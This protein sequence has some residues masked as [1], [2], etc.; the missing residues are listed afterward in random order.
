MSPRPIFNLL[1]LDY[2]LFLYYSCFVWLV[3]HHTHDTQN[4]H[5]DVVPSDPTHELCFSFFLTKEC[6]EGT[7]QV[8]CGR[9]SMQQVRDRRDQ[10]PDHRP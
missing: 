4:D 3:D 5:C 9:M 10:P 8:V 6:E 2:A 7:G 1:S